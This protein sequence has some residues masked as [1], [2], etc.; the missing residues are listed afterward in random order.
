MGYFLFF[1]HFDLLLTRM[2]SQEEGMKSGSLLFS[3]WTPKFPQVDI[4]IYY[5]TLNPNPKAKIT[6]IE[7]LLPRAN[8]FI[9]LQPFALLSTIY[10][11]QKFHE[12]FQF[13][14]TLFKTSALS[15]KFYCKNHHTA[16]INMFV[17]DSRVF[18]SPK[19]LS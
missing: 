15:K 1:P 16:T 19:S 2:H 3:H 14:L 11:P 13:Y 17:Q 5:Q 10:R 18:A 9:K 12:N 8:N 7:F 4:L 6:S